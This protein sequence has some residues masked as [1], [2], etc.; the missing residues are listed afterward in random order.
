MAVKEKNSKFAATGSVEGVM[1]LP[2][3][4]GDKDLF[5]TLYWPENTTFVAKKQNYMGA[6]YL[7]KWTENPT[8][9]EVLRSRIAFARDRSNDGVTSDYVIS[10]ADGNYSNSCGQL[11]FLP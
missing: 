5:C 9:Q 2:Y 11:I 3:G 4:E 7:I 1:Y 10:R 6:S 8:P